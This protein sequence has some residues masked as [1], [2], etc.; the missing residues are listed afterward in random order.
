M[1][2]KKDEEQVLLST[3]NEEEIDYVHKSRPKHYIK[4]EV[5]KTR[6]LLLIIV[7]VLLCLLYLFLPLECKYV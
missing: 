1:D 7:L 6:I 2:R 4:I 3:D 5:T